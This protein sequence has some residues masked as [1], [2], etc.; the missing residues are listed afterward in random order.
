MRLLRTLGGLCTCDL[1]LLGVVV[2][3]DEAPRTKLKKQLG[4]SSSRSVVGG[5]G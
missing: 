2:V 4:D 1:R 5:G 3:A